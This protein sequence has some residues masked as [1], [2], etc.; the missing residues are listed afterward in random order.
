MAWP[1]RTTYRI[2]DDG[3]ADEDI[4]LDETAAEEG[5]DIEE[6]EAILRT[7]WTITNLPDIQLILLL[8]ASK[9]NIA[10][11]ANS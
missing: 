9:K 3:N 7:A 10:N 11:D 6:E 8:I 2:L 5:E 4:F 1:W